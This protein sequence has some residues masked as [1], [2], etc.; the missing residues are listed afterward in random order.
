MRFEVETEKPIPVQQKIFDMLRERP[1]MTMTLVVET[2][3]LLSSMNYH[4]YKL[5]ETEFVNRR[6]VG[7]GNEWYVK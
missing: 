7:N 6:R 1:M 5:R 3:R 4:L 2:G